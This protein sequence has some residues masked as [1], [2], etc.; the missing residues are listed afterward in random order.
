MR[1][2]VGCLAIAIL[3]LMT[4]GAHPARAHVSYCDLAP[5][6]CYFTG[7]GRRHFLVPGSRLQR[8][9]AA[10]KISLSFL[11]ERRRRQRECA[12]HASNGYCGLEPA[13]ARTGPPR[14][15]WRYGAF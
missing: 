12:L 4:I 5:D 2:L 1:G 14:R 10:G 11:V 3:V 6:N 15:W 7:D 8:A 13:F 9:Y